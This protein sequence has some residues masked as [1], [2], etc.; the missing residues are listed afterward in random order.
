MAAYIFVLM[1][2]LDDRINIGLTS[3]LATYFGNRADSPLVNLEQSR[4][5]ALS[6]DAQARAAL[7]ALYGTLAA[8]EETA[9]ASG[10]LPSSRWFCAQALVPVQ[11]AID[12]LRANFETEILRL[13]AFLPAADIERADEIEAILEATPRREAAPAAPALSV[14]QLLT[15]SAQAL[16]K[17]QRACGANLAL[18]PAT[19]ALGPCATHALVGMFGAEQFNEAMAALGELELGSGTFFASQQDTEIARVRQDL[20]WAFC[21]DVIRPTDTA[22][23]SGSAAADPTE[24]ARRK[25]ARTAL[26]IAGWDKPMG[27]EIL[28]G[29]VLE[30]YFGAPLKSSHEEPAP[31][32]GSDG[33]PLRHAG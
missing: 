1:N 3:N 16:A 6:S 29:A 33:T 7:E 19:P 25:L 22:I 18:L 23:A 10:S 27:N 26:G 20:D 30:T 24:E 15:I 5:L 11:F 2:S 13:E 32:A 17:L 31:L 9:P 14:E 28:L 4:A 12:D 8:F 21:V